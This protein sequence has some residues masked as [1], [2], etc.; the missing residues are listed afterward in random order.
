M[1]ELVAEMPQ[2]VVDAAHEP[3][4]ARAVIYASLLDRD[5]DIR[6]VQLRALEQ[7]ADR[8]CV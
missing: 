3:Y 8:K 5:A 1:R 7:L 2:D 6:A 4:G